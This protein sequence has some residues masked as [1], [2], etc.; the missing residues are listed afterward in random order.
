VL[1]A[2]P[3]S[4]KYMREMGFKTFDKWWDESYDT[5]TDHTRRLMKILDLI[6]HIDSLTDA[7][8]VNMYREMTPTLM[9][10]AENLMKISM[11]NGMSHRL[12]K[13]TDSSMGIQ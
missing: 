1:V 9:H 13:W 11:D 2:P 6:E 7:Q 8:C 5:E 4:L 12:R 10:N 3:L